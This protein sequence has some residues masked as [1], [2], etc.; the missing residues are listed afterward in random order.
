MDQ[1]LTHKQDFQV[2]PRS[3]KIKI[4]GWD[5]IKKNRQ[6]QVSESFAGEEGKLGR[7]ESKAHS[8][9]GRESQPALPTLAGSIESCCISYAI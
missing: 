4:G 5:S 7:K 2:F 1:F 9:S 6:Q 3:L 8:F